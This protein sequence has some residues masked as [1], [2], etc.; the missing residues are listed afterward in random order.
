MT[1]FKYV[2]VYMVYILT[3]RSKSSNFILPTINVYLHN[4]LTLIK[5][6][7]KKP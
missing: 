3:F 7:V 1:F 4:S 6:N 2:Y 5:I